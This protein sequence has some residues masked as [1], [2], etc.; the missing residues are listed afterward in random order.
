MFK[1]DV[2]SRLQRRLC[3]SYMDEGFAMIA[4]RNQWQ[5]YDDR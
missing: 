1:G 4:G 5:K 2:Y 3:F